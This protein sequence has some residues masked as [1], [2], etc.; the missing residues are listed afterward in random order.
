MF[1]PPEPGWV[2]VHR[3][4]CWGNKPAP[5]INHP[6]LKEAAG[7]PS[8]ES[9]DQLSWRPADLG[10]LRNGMVCGGAAP[11]GARTQATPCTPTVSQA[12]RGHGPGKPGARRLLCPPRAVSQTHGSQEPERGTVGWCSEEQGPGFRSGQ[13]RQGSL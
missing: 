4:V 11:P 2:S 9:W 8:G 13:S 1:L 3:E 10:L 5:N 6:V 7:L 12:L